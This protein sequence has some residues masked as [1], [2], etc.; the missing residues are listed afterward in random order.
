[1]R[2]V[3]RLLM[4]CVF[5][6]FLFQRRRKLVKAPPCP[7]CADRRPGAACVAL[8]Y[9]FPERCIRDRR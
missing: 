1:M 2:L 3:S 7:H 5:R 4:L 9:G 8:N 6:L